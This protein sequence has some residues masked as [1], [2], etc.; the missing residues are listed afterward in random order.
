MACASFLHR[1]GASSICYTAFN[2]LI[3][4]YG[5]RPCQKLCTRHEW[6]TLSDGQKAE[7]IGAVRCLQTKPAIAPVFP[8]A[9]TRFDE[10]Q[11]YHLQQG[12]FI[13]HVGQFL[14]WHRYWL[15]LYEKALRDECGYQGRNPYW[16]WTIDSDSSTSIR[17]SPVFD[18]Y[19]GFGGDG[20]PG[21]YTLPPCIPPDQLVFPDKWRG[22]I[23]DGPFANYTV[24]LGPGKLH[25]TH[26]VVR[27]IDDAYAVYLDS[28]AIGRLMA[29]PTFE[30]FRYELEGMPETTDHRVHDG[31]H[32][33][34]GGEMSN[35]YSS[36][37]DP[38]FY[39]HHANLDRIWWNWQ[40]HDPSNRLYQIGGHTS[41]GAPPFTNVSLDFPLEMSSSIGPTISIWQTMNIH[42]EHNCYTYV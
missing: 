42:S 30:V 3:R 40:Q 15:Q 36:G 16:D 7:Y 17:G 1:L 23:A 35:Q 18:P 38:L 41:F 19:T 9:V 26:C 32:L 10:F 37:S 13:H 4:Q 5:Q 14:P 29:S 31:G 2:A 6:R 8:E 20:V 39:L 22:C 21:T 25:T 34:V 11:A 27:Q 33:S 12:D 28:P 24:R